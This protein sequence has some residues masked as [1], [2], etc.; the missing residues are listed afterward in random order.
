MESI[1]RLNDD[2]ISGIRDLIEINIDSCKG[3]QDAAGKIENTGIAGMFRECSAERERFADELT[4]IISANG[5]DAP[6]S[7][8]VKGT[9]HRWWMNI[10]GTIA[11]GDEHA[12]LAEAERGEDAIKTRYE[13][14]LLNTAGSAVNDLLQRQYA[15]VKTR[16]DQI[17]DMRD[18]GK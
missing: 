18:A 4:N 10:R 17:R 16:H 12:I 11:D 15:R 7:G 9:A 6:T 3:F 13:Q 8:T 5:K 1:N 14:T 2:T